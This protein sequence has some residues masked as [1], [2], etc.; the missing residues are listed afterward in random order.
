[1]REGRR[2]TKKILFSVLYAWGNLKS[3]RIISQDIIRMLYK[4]ETQESDEYKGE[5]SML[6]NFFINYIIVS[7]AASAAI[8][9][10][11]GRKR[12]RLWSQKLYVTKFDLICLAISVPFLRFSLTQFF[13]SHAHIFYLLFFFILWF[14]LIFYMRFYA[15]VPI[16]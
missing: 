13:S 16:S 6:K 8:T 5:T 9:A 2:S 7:S 15:W 4:K 11:K 1:M 3:A 14:W 10:V 12:R